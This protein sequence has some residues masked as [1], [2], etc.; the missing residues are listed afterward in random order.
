M[1][2]WVSFAKDK[3][4]LILFDAAYVDFIR[5]ESLP[6]SIFEID[7]AHEV[8]VEFRSFS[9][10][11]GFHGYA[12][13]LHSRPDKLAWQVM[14]TVIPFQCAESLDASSDHQI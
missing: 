2:Q 14:K 12:L 7:G 13:R 11:A 8:A 4:A 5:E 1:E 9:K 3:Q 6:H 10:M